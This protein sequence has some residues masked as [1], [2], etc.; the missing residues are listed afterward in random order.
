MAILLEEMTGRRRPTHG[1]D[2]AMC[3]YFNSPA[4]ESP[5]G[6]RP[7][8]VKRKRRQADPPHTDVIEVALRDNGR[9][10]VV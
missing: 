6:D 9:R 7:P 2:G 4:T 10:R 1:G 8:G 5:R 3:A